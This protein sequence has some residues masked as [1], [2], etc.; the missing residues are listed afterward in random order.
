M[1]N[2]ICTENCKTENQ[3]HSIGGRPIAYNPKEDSV[4][5]SVWHMVERLFFNLKN[6]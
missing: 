2:A 3:V 4:S 6:Q 1:M 5:I